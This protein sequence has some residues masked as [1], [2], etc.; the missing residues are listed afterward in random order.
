[1]LWHNYCV[2]ITLFWSNSKRIVVYNSGKIR[3]WVFLYVKCS[4]GFLFSVNPTFP[5]L[6][7][8]R[9][10][11]RFSFRGQGTKG[12]N[13][14]SKFNGSGT[15]INRHKCGRSDNRYFFLISLSKALFGNS[16]SRGVKAKN[17]SIFVFTDLVVILK[18][19]KINYCSFV[20]LFLMSFRF[21]HGSDRY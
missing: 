8:S 12:R 20:A 9:R 13:G 4:D 11:I 19:F 21:E 6:G 7:I 5:C 10:L 14:R 15:F 2:G 1:M 3:V 17:S 16:A 18:S